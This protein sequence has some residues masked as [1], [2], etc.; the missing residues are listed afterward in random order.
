VIQRK[1]AQTSGGMADCAWTSNKKA[2][3]F[4]G[5]GSWFRSEEGDPGEKWFALT[6]AEI[7]RQWNLSVLV[8]REIPDK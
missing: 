8:K 2:L 7:G 3:Y 6:P 5:A 4:C 1:A